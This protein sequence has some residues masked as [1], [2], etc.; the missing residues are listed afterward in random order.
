MQWTNWLAVLRQV[1]VE[2]F[3]RFV[4]VLKEDFVEAVDLAGYQS[5]SE[6]PCL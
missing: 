6:I 3:G 2:L 4:G 1:V 5:L